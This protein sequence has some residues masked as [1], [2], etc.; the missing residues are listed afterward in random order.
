M[1][2]EEENEQKIKKY[3]SILDLNEKSP[4]LA[5]IEKLYIMKNLCDLKDEEA[6]QILDEFVLEL[7]RQ[8]ENEDN[9][10]SKDMLKKVGLWKEK[11]EE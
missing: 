10:V 9:T 11:S 7:R 1:S 2:D 4:F 5:P 8:A 3:R 6:C